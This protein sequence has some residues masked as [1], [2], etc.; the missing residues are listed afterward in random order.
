MGEVWFFGL[1]ADPS[2]PFPP[3][4]PLLLRLRSRFQSPPISPSLA[5]P[6]EEDPLK[7]S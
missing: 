1:G 4:P 6:L 3:S 2:L 5:L 7:S